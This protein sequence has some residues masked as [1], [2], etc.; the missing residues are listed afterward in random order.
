M[1]DALCIRSAGRQSKSIGD[2]RLSASQSDRTCLEKPGLIPISSK[3][4]TNKGLNSQTETENSASKNSIIGKSSDWRMTAII[5]CISKP[6]DNHKK[7]HSA[8]FYDDSKRSVSNC[9]KLLY[10]PAHSEK[11]AAYISERLRA[12]HSHLKRKGRGRPF[13]A[14]PRLKGMLTFQGISRRISSCR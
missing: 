7:K 13:Q 14:D 12:G 5:L 2:R 9:C 3:M 11:L 4:P 6:M 10:A 1:P 8:F